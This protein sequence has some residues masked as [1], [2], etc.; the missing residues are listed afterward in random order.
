M[1]PYNYA[2]EIFFVTEGQMIDGERYDL[3]LIDQSMSDSTL[4]S[5]M[6]EFI[7]NRKNGPARLMVS[8]REDENWE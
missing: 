7:K 1:K 8:N 6:E 4:R 2:K 5:L 3:S